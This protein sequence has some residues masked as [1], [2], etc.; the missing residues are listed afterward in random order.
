MIE[1]HKH[2]ALV[3]RP[4]H[5]HSIDVGVD[6]ALNALARAAL[7]QVPAARPLSYGQRA[8]RSASRPRSSGVL[9]AFALSSIALAAA[10][11]RTFRKVNVS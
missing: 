3:A 4:Q 7:Q 6:V 5:M 1:H 11:M 2:D 9:Q 8:A 10:A